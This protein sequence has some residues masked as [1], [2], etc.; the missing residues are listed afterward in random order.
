MS[1]TNILVLTDPDAFLFHCGPVADNNAVVVETIDD[2][3]D[4]LA[5]TRSKTCAARSD[6]PKSTKS[7]DTKP[8]LLVV[9]SPL[10]PMPAYTYE[11]K[12]ATPNAAKQIHQAILSTSIPHIS[13]AD[14]LP[15][16]LDL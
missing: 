9:Q 13:V 3:A 8:N 6:L 7:K 16:S 14:L 11:S 4:I 2:E 12:A 5:I 1:A 10:K 15:I